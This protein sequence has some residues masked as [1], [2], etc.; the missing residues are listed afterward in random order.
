M[1]TYF[2]IIF[3][4][5]YLLLGAIS[6]YYV[7]LT[8]YLLPCWLFFAFGNGTIGHRYFA[9]NQF[10]VGK[11]KHF[12]FSLWCTISAYSPI[13]YWKVQ[14][15]HHH[16]HSDSEK[17]IHSP[18]NGIIQSLFLWPFNKT[19]IESVFKDRSSIVLLHRTKEDKIITFFSN[20][21][22]IVNLFFLILIFSIDKTLLFYAAIS[23]LLEHIRLGLINTICHIKSFPGNYK[24]TL[25]NDSSYN[26]IF[27]GIIF[28]GFGWH[29]NHHSN[30]KNL[31][32][33]EKWWELD[34]EGLLGKLLSK[35]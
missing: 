16:R 17:D 30:P 3:N 28:L 10:E 23:F 4:F 35:R 7:E 13:V 11:I 12:L 5:F 26:N 32:L 22:V 33:T 20:Y 8:W 27:L 21:F 14:H 1:K 2:L 18:K 9:H 34:L 25:T 29:N 6:L 15:L 31:L 24:N 19:R